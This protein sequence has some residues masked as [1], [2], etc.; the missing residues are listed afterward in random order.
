MFT[1]RPHVNLLTV[2]LFVKLQVM[3]EKLDNVCRKVRQKEGYPFGGLQMIV[4]GD[5]KQLSPVPS[6]YYNDLGDY[7]FLSPVFQSAFPHHVNLEE[8]STT[9]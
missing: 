8:V 2:S 6:T 4:S 9:L 1:F 5:F 7:C 3:F